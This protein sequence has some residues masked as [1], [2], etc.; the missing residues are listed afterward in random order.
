MKGLVYETSVLDPDEVSILMGKTTWWYSFFEWYYTMIL[1][2]LAAFLYILYIYLPKYLHSFSSF[3]FIYLL[4]FTLMHRASVSE[5]T[6]FQSARSCCPK[7]QEVRSRC[8]RVSS[9]CWSQDRRPQR[10]RLV[11]KGCW[12]HICPCVP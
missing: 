2:T 7:L 1:P 11:G 5:A 4:I 9:G 10:S 6:A 12:C 8:L 3:L